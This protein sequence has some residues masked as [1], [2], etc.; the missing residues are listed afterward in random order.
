MNPPSLGQMKRKITDMASL[1]S[2]TADAL[3]PGPCQ[4]AARCMAA[5]HG[6]EAGLS[7]LGAGHARIMLQG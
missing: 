7:G 3:S 6:L 2:C 1:P 5:V 4:T